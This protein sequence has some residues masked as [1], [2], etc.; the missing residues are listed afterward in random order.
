MTRRRAA[1]GGSAM[2]Q[3]HGRVVDAAVRARQG[4]ER[5]AALRQ[6]HGRGEGAAPVGAVEVLVHAV[7]A[8]REDAAALERVH[9]AL[10]PAVAPLPTMRAG[11]LAEP[12][13]GGVSPRW[14]KVSSRVSSSSARRASPRGDQ[15]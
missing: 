13:G 2:Q 15:R 7:A 9:A 10:A 14:P 5:P 8:E 3:Q 11:S 12:P 6:R 4:D 1:Q